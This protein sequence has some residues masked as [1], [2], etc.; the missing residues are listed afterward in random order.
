M[1]RLAVGE[2]YH[3]TRRQWPEA[4]HLRLTTDGSE[5]TLFL[6]SPTTREIQAVRRGKA[7][8]AWVD[9]EHTAVLAFRFDDGVP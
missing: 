9:S 8:F 2:P 4:P 1:Y 5:L 6:R 3:P 7:K